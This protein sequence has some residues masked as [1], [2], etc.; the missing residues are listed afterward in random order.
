MNEID[1]ETAAISHALKLLDEGK[2]I[3]VILAATPAEFR[4]KVSEYIEMLKWIEAE[5][6]EVTV[7]KAAFEKILAAIPAE[8]ARKSALPVQAA[9]AVPAKQ[10][11]SMAI[12]KLKKADGVFVRPAAVVQKPE[13]KASSPAISW[14]TFFGKDSSLAQPAKITDWKVWLPTGAVALLLVIIGMRGES[15]GVVTPSMPQTLAVSQPFP[16]GQ[17][18]SS[19]AQAPVAKTAALMAPAAASPVAI[20]PG[21]DGAA[22]ALSSASDSEAAAANASDGDLAASNAQ[23][24]NQATRSYDENSI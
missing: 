23:L 9:E 14:G 6:D 24:L 18:A 19:P 17:A 8:E 2:D 5:R 7:P 13:E 1:L 20:P 16:V 12:P 11:L 3:R 10:R 4:G 22:S 21:I 15:S